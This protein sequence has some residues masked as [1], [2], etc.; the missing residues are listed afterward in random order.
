MGEY[1]K[2]AND[3]GSFGLHAPHSQPQLQFPHR[4]RLHSRGLRLP[5]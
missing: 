4:A 2:S 5:G 1:V 3:S